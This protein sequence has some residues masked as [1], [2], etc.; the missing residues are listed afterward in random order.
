MKN[1]LKTIDFSLF[2]NLGQN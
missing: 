2:R 1:N